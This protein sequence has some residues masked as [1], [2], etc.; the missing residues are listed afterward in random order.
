[1]YVPLTFHCFVLLSIVGP[2]YKC[3]PDP[4][5]G[6]SAPHIWDRWT[7]DRY[8]GDTTGET[9]ILLQSTKYI[10]VS[11]KATLFIVNCE[12]LPSSL[13]D[14]NKH[15]TVILNSYYSYN[16]PVTIDNYIHQ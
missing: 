2:H 11:N 10:K 12:C 14:N 1:M 7:T 5:G 16:T 4:V 15:V 9:L 8:G 3:F 6:T 13:V